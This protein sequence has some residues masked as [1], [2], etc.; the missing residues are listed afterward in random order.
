MVH[1]VRHRTPAGDTITH[2]VDDLEAAVAR[3]ERLRNDDKAEDVRVFAEVPLQFETYVR[4][5]VADTAPPPVADTPAASSE[6]AVDDDD[7]A[8]APPVTPPPPPS[9]VLAPVRVDAP[10]ADADELVDATP[11]ES[12]KGMLFHRGSASS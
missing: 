3:V 4:V 7:P 10:S 12:R 8:P 2:E 11:V 5:R 6:S 1:L 9:G